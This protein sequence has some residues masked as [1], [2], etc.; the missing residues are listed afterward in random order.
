MIICGNLQKPSSYS[1]SSCKV[2]HTLWSLCVLLGISLM[3][4][5]QSSGFPV[6]PSG[7][8]SPPCHTYYVTT[9]NLLQHTKD[10]RQELLSPSI[11][12]RKK[13]EGWLRKKEKKFN[14]WHPSV[15][16]AQCDW[17]LCPSLTVLNL[18]PNEHELTTQVCLGD[19]S[20]SFQS[21]PIHSNSVLLMRVGSVG[22]YESFEHV[23]IFCVASAN[24]FHSCL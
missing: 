1:A 24:K 5:E 19:H 22:E 6:H 4:L 23:Q 20:W 12:H 10:N 11:H 13:I 17:G 14:R 9:G 21:I 3:L 7:L 8:H 16:S 15:D 18:L 2:L